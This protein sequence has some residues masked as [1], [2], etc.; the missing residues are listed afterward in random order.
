MEFKIDGRRLFYLDQGR[1]RAVLILHGADLAIPGSWDRPFQSLVEAG[2]RVVL[3]YGAGRGPSDPRPDFNSLIRDARDC[4]AL[5]DHLGLRRAVLIGHSQGA[6]VAEQMLLGRPDRVAAVI[7]EDSAAFG[8]L[9]AEIMEMGTDRFDAETLALYEKHKSTLAEFGRPWEYPSEY[10][11]GRMLK[12]RGF[13]RRTEGKRQGHSPDPENLSAP[14]GK[15]CR[16]PL[17]AFAAGRGRIRPGD[18]E[19]IALEKKLPAENARLVVVTE[20]G[21]GIHEEQADLFIRE[22]LDFLASLPPE[23]G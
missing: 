16:V 1:G 12:R 18:P 15:Y 23:E 13:L 2:Y 19:A 17:L 22:V 8:K 9:K 11:V 6:C 5:L 14:E 4:W 3:P 20:S 10:N 7:S 21:H